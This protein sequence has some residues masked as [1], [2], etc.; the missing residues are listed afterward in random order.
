MRLK[1]I[2][3]SVLFILC[4]VETFAEKH[5]TMEDLKKLLDSK[6]YAEIL[7]T[8]RKVPP[9]KR[10]KDWITI[11]GRAAAFKLESLI[12][13]GQENYA[14]QMGD[15]IEKESP[16]IGDVQDFNKAMAKAALNGTQKGLA[17]IY[18]SK[19]LKQDDPACKTEGVKSSVV[20]VL[21]KYI[22]AKS[23]AAAEQVAF[24]FCAAELNKEWVTDMIASQRG[25]DNSCP[26]LLKSGQL[27]GVALVKCQKNK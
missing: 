7:S 19:T 2:F 17:I 15:E 21:T 22:D 18:L 20:E 5:L 14:Y 24:K 1:R 10:T 9:S 16:L 4:S 12:S 13:E 11:Y 23:L 6:E 3:L 8:A 26:G 27:Q 25:L